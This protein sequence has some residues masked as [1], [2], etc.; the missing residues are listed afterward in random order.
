MAE[1]SRSMSLESAVTTTLRTSLRSSFTTPDQA[2]YA[3]T[4]QRHVAQ[5]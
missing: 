3:E 5:R 2:M 4:A 1:A